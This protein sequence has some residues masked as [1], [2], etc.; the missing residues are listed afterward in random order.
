MNNLS[1]TY[2]YNDLA[3][4]NAITQ[5]GKK[6]EAKALKE[7]ARQFESMFVGIMLKSMRDANAVF[8]ESNPLSSNE[9]KFYRKMFDDQLSLSLSKG[10]GMGLADT[11]Y[12]QLKQQFD[13]KEHAKTI[14]KDDHTNKAFSLNSE[15]TPLSL[16]KPATSIPVPVDPLFE[17]KL[18][19]PASVGPTPTSTPNQVNEV[20]NS[21]PEDTLNNVLGVRVNNPQINTDVTSNKDVIQA[22]AG[23]VK[24]QSGFESPQE[25]VNAI[26]PIAQ[27]IATVMSVEPKAIIAQAALET[28]WGKHIIHQQDGKNSHNLFGIKADRR[29]DGDVAK[30]STLEYKNGL[31]KKEVAPFRVYDSYESSLKD[32]ANFIKDSSR[33]KEAVQQGAN[34]QGYSEGLQ[35][36][37]YATDP[38][39]ANKIQRI[40]AGDLL[41]N[42]INQVKRG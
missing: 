16:S 1:N 20:K 37:G 4:L 24:K 19:K 9:S 40:A 5:V 10:K 35:K 23:P 33:Y 42:A 25:F 27:K 26:W 18:N 22:Q 14:S 34:V 17:L 15:P 21:Q 29:W 38:N 8:E 41:N 2:S 28:G 6:D 3:S 31:A 7:V 36:G 32:Y 11:L 39:Y 12:R 30:V 13:V